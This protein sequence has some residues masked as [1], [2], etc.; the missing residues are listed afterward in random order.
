M[1]EGANFFMNLSHMWPVKWEQSRLRVYALVVFI[2][3]V[4]H[5]ATLYSVYI[6]DINHDPK[7][8][9][10]FFIAH[11]LTASIVMTLRQKT[12]VDNYRDVRR[13]IVGKVRKT[14]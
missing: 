3:A 8:S 14:D 10:L 5:V 7:D 12:K 2:D 9:P 11:F 13:L 1:L 4:A 6:T